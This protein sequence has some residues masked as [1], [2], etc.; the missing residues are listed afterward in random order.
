ML[1]QLLIISV[2]HSDID[3][4]ERR[5]AAICSCNVA[6][7]SRSSLDGTVVGASAAKT[8][9]LAAMRRTLAMDAARPRADL[10]RYMAHSSIRDRSGRNRHFGD[11]S[12]LANRNAA[13]HRQFP[14]SMVALTRPVARNRFLL[15]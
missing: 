12:M 15:R 3:L 6:I 11:L 9:L 4:S 8:G 2:R 5:Q 14:Q 1:W 13:G 10:E 7:C